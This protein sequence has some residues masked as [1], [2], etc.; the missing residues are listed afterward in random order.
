MASKTPGSTLSIACCTKWSHL[1]CPYSIGGSKT[2]PGPDEVDIIKYR[3]GSIVQ[4]G[5]VVVI[6][7]SVDKLAN[8][9][10]DECHLPDVRE[11]P[12][13]IVRTKLFAEHSV[14]CVTRLS[15]KS[16][17][18]SSLGE[19]HREVSAL[20]ARP[21]STI[22]RS[23]NQKIV[24]QYFIPSLRSPQSSK[25]AAIANSFDTIQKRTRRFSKYSVTAIELISADYL[26]ALAGLQQLLF[27]THRSTTIMKWQAEFRKGRCLSRNSWNCTC[28]NVLTGSVFL[29]FFRLSDSI[30][31]KWNP[32]RL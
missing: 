19:K 16:L 12:T 3:T 1:I 24:I 4:T 5:F 17:Y 27:L 20:A 29:A 9:A 26:N 18:S 22:M 11:S 15:N 14:P 30:C 8:R 10:V 25:V 2:Q 6:T 13:K 28:P 31:H 32:R 21:V 7:E 23:L